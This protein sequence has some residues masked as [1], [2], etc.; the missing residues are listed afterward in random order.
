MANSHQLIFATGWHDVRALSVPWPH[1]G[2]TQRSIHWPSVMYS[3]PRKELHKSDYNNRYIDAVAMPFI[4]IRERI[5]KESEWYGIISQ[6]KWLTPGHYT[7]EKTQCG[8]NKPRLTLVQSSWG[9]GGGGL[10]VAPVVC[11]DVNMAVFGPSGWGR[12]MLGVCLRI[13][14]G[15]RGGGAEVKNKSFVLIQPGLYRM[16]V[17]RELPP[18]ESLSA[19]YT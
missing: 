4:S 13:L 16:P 2:W 3:V 6:Y 17:A 8:G 12:L 1:E 9:G 15:G 14:A 19:D 10:D 7:R 11:W 18:R 5:K